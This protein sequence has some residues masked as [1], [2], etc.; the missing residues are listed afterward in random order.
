[1]LYGFCPFESTTI[2]KLIEVLKETE[3]DFPA[4]EPVSNETKVFLRRLLT[5]DPTKR[6]EWM[7]LLSTKISSE[8]K[9]AENRT[10]LSLTQDTPLYESSRMLESG[11]ITPIAA[12]DDRKEMGSTGSFS[13]PSHAYSKL[14]TDIQTAATA[15]VPTPVLPKKR[16][17]LTLKPPACPT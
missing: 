5:K 16:R 7:E 17:A 8:G 2:P 14:D 1:M 13:P 11:K 4:K 6:I 3:L 9:L 15:T 12:K 10:V